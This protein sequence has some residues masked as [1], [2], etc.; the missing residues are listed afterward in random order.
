MREGVWPD[1]PLTLHSIFLQGVHIFQIA[2]MTLLLGPWATVHTFERPDW[3]P[4]NPCFLVINP[5][6]NIAQCDEIIPSR[7]MF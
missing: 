1:P 3:F 2:V 4:V 7:V 6:V 5:I